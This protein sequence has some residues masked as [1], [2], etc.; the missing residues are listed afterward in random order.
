MSWLESFSSSTSA[1]LAVTTIAGGVA[2]IKARPLWHQH[3]ERQK[4]IEDQLDPNTPG[5][6]SDVIKAIQETK[7]Q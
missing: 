2:W 1:G 6:V 7:E 3:V 4:R 5:G